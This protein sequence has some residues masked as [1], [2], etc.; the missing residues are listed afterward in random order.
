[1]KTFSPPSVWRLLPVCF[2]LVAGS[3]QA[4]YIFGT[5]NATNSPYVYGHDYN[6]LSGATSVVLGD[7]I[8][9]GTTLITNSPAGSSSFGVMATTNSGDV[10]TAARQVTSDTNY[11]L[12]S[13]ASGYKS[14]SIN[15]LFSGGI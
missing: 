12:S 6:G 4:Q 15:W 11:Y 2:L 1:M 14:N 5:D 13:Q 8:N 10:S 7:W 3:V 9:S